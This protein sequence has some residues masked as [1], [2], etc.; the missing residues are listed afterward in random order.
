VYGWYESVLTNIGYN[1]SSIRLGNSL[2]ILRGVFYQ[3]NTSCCISLMHCSF[4]LWWNVYSWTCLTVDHRWMRCWIE[5]W[6]NIAGREERWH[7]SVGIR[8]DF[9]QSLFIANCR[10]CSIIFESFGLLLYH[11]FA[12][13]ISTLHDILL[14]INPIG[15]CS[16]IAIEHEFDH[17]LNLIGVHLANSINVVLHSLPMYT[18]LF[19]AITFLILVL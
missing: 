9:I 4:W 7:F 11:T 6:G 2:I 8:Y 19:I 14:Q 10:I 15:S 18:G 12:Y 16:F 5:R 17:I 1:L 13:L 3:R